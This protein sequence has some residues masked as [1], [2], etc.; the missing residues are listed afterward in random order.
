MSYPAAC[1][2]LALWTLPVLWGRLPWAR[3]TELR[4]AISGGLLALGGPIPSYP[5]SDMAVR[6][7]GRALYPGVFFETTE[8]TRDAKFESNSPWP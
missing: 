6:L 1:V 3:K 5:G 2:H 4:G 7:A 8:I